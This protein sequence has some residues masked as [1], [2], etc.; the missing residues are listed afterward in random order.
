MQ[1]ARWARQAAR[2]LGGLLGA[3]LI[4]ELTLR[5]MLG[6]GVITLPVL[7]DAARP[8]VIWGMPRDLT[9][10]NRMW[11]ATRGWANVQGTRHVLWT[12]QGPQRT[13][14]VNHIGARRVGEVSAEPS[15]SVRRVVAVGDSFTFGSEVSDDQVWLA[16]AEQRAPATE[17]VNLGVGGY[18][19]D[20]ALLTLREVGLGLRPDV[21][22]FGFVGEDIERNVFDFTFARKPRFVLQDGVLVEVGAPVP[23]PDALLKADRWRLRSLDLLS[24]ASGRSTAVDW[25]ESNP[26]ALALIQAVVTESRA[27]GALVLL[28]YLPGTLPGVHDLDP[29]PRTPVWDHACA[30]QGVSCLDLRPVFR[31]ARD[32]GVDLLEIT[33]WSPEAH[34]LAADALVAALVALPPPPRLSASGPG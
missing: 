25:A 14:T 33:H 6:V 12:K 17:I 20:Q 30:T 18:G 32:R 21:V 24:V 31:A 4:F 8:Q 15:P 27:A 1:G 22:V 2:G 19:Q 28:V 7:G 10:P 16:L 13:E 11:S 5:A 26:L 3:A 23:S 9:S 34:V 29:S